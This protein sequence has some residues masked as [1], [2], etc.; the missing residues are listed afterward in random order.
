M[1]DPLGLRSVWEEAVLCDEVQG[2]PQVEVVA[3]GEE[4]RG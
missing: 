2:W 4:E 3:V 1:V